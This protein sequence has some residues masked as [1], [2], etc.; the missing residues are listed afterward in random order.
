MRLSLAEY[1]F[2]REERKRRREKEKEKIFGIKKDCAFSGG[3]NRGGSNDDDDDDD[4][5][6]SAC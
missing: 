6:A 2:F 4:D 3:I 5:A 1:V